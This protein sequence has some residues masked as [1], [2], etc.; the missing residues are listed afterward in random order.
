LSTP[1][2]S[3]KPK[4]ASQVVAD[5]LA[6]KRKQNKFLRNVGIQNDQPQSGS[7][8]LN[9]QIELEMEKRAKVE[10]RLI[11]NTQ[12]AQM[13]DLSHQVKVID[14]A[15]I[16][17]QEEMKKQQVELNVKLELLLGQGRLG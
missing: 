8:V 17:D 7:S 1:T 2:E 16:I 9:I 5:V 14:A 12:C 13:D 10:L 6:Q 4:S 3:E 15:R 11:V